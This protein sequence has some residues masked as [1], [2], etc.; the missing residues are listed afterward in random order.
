MKKT[1]YR[2]LEYQRRIQNALAYIRDNLDK[3]LFVHEVARIACFSEFH[4]HRIFSAVM[5]ETLGEYITRKKLERAAM[6]IAYTSDPVVSHIAFDYGYSSVSSFSKAFKQWFGCRPTEISKIKQNLESANGKLQTKYQKQIN[7]DQLYV[8]LT[9]DELAQ[10]SKEIDRRVQIQS[11]PQ[12]ELFYLTS[13]GGYEFSSIRRT[14][15]D[16]AELLE[17]AHININECQRYSISH[18]HP[19]LTPSEHCRYDAC[20][21]LPNNHIRELPLAKI[22][23]PAG[24]YALFPVEGPEDSIL[25]QY[26]EFYSIWMPQSGYAPDNFPIVEHYLQTCVEGFLAI[27]LLAKITRLSLF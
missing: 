12:I 3:P 13:P 24:R 22:T 18:D 8:E 14:W 1:R 25:D 20:I 9:Q 6:K 23:V 19:A 7:F 17:D 21:A 26:L 10:R 16:L 4:F 5:H 2:T 27:E 15:S 11:I